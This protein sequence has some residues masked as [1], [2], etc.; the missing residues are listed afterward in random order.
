MSQS[1]WIFVVVTVGIVSAIA[2]VG[3]TLMGMQAYKSGA[4]WD[5]PEGF[6]SFATQVLRIATVITILG[7]VLILTLQGTEL[8]APVA[9]ILSGIAGYVLGGSEKFVKS[10]SGRKAREAAA[11]ERGPQEII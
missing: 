7:T 8:T 1:F 4:M 2:T 10:Q 3:L 6:T 5:A 11:K 9:G